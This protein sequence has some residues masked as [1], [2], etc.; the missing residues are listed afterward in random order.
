MTADRL[1]DRIKAALEA[2]QP[3]VYP[4]LPG[5]K[6]HLEAGV[7]VPLLLEPEVRVL[8]TVR[9]RGLRDHGGEICFPGGRPEPDDLDLRATAEREAREEIGLDSGSFLGRL[10][11]IPLYTSDYRLVPWVMGV[12]PQK[13]RTQPGEVAKLLSVS[14]VDMLNK[15]HWDGIPFEWQGQV[16]LSPVFDV[17]EPKMLYGGTAHVFYEL[18]SV[19]APVLDCAMPPLQSGRFAWQDLLGTP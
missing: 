2:H 9:A 1:I 11:S 6:N 13:F 12:K 14:V 4:A 7:L 3:Q 17:G 5:R 8:L 10:S 18:L 16:H 19:I 15:P